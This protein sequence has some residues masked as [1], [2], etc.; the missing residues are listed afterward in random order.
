A[1]PAK[2]IRV[3]TNPAPRGVPMPDST[4]PQSAVGGRESLYIQERDSRPARRLP[5]GAEPIAGGRTH[6]R[7]WAP[8]AGRIAVIIDGGGAT[9]LDAEDG[10]YF[11]GLVDAGV[12][13]RY[14]F[15]VGE[16]ER[17]YPDPASR[18]QPEGPHGP[19]EIVDAAAF[20][21]SDESWPGVTL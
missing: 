3:G 18:F 13:A 16:D 14:R 19:S 11:S 6:F 7:V 20:E 9:N 12:R 2:T 15:R 5:I 17:G 8:A 1:E 10:G 4:V 21:W